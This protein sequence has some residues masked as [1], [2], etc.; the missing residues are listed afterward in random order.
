MLTWEEVTEPDDLVRPEEREILEE[1]AERLERRCSHLK[2][3]GDFFYYCN[4][5]ITDGIA[6]NM[7]PFDPIIYAQ[8]S[9][10]Q[11]QLHCFDRFE[12]CC[13]YKGTLPWPSANLID[14]E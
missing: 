5:G 4:G 10:A 12:A 7:K 9:T 13:H 6:P 1:A 3:L 14:R 8:Q 2:K 11:I